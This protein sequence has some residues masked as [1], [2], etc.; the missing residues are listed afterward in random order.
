MLF[1]MQ[2]FKSSLC[3]VS[4][5]WNLFCN[6]VDYKHIS[7]LVWVLCSKYISALTQNVNRQISKDTYKFVSNISSGSA[8]NQLLFQNKEELNPS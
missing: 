3:S 4:L 5:N 8:E 2:Y 1:L 7:A 6:F